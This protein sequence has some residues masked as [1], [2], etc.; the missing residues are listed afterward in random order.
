[1]TIS[2]HICNTVKTEEI[3]GNVVSTLFKIDKHNLVAEL[4]NDL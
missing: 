1:M 4:P 2:R 3:R